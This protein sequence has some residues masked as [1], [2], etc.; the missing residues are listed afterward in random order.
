MPAP[1]MWELN[2]ALATG[3]K[4]GPIPMSGCVSRVVSARRYRKGLPH[5]VHGQCTKHCDVSRPMAQSGQ[6]RKYPR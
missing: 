5:P 1:S 4:T 3:V 2:C 6:G